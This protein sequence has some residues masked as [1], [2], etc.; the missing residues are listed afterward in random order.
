MHFED[1]FSDWLRT[2]QEEI[3]KRVLAES[4]MQCAEAALR[5]GLADV[6]ERMEECERRCKE[7]ERERR[8][9]DAQ[10]L[11]KETA[12]YEE[13]L[14]KYGCYHC[15]CDR[16]EARRNQPSSDEEEEDIFLDPKDLPVSSPL[17]K[18]QR[19]RGGIGGLNKLRKIGASGYAR[20]DGARAPSDWHASERRSLCIAQCATTLRSGARDHA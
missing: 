8:E 4:K 17:R 18:I 7:G 13:G 5:D 20:L 10:V 6:D 9:I 15:K 19:G 11:E 2:L 14:R 3:G 12:S 16:C 1:I